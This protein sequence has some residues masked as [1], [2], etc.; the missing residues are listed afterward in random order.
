M[1]EL[2]DEL[3]QAQGDVDAKDKAIVELEALLNV[4]KLEQML[5]TD[6]WRVSSGD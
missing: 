2:E 1:T 6:G 5:G 3:S 4:Q